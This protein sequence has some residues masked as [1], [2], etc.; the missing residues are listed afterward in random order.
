M[1]LNV[2]LMRPEYDNKIYVECRLYYPNTGAG[3]FVMLVVAGVLKWLVTLT[4]AGMFVMLAVAGVFKKA[5]DSH[6]W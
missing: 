2:N 4:G 6:R 5:G 3:M 1:W